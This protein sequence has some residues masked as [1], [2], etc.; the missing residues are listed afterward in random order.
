MSQTLNT[1]EALNLWHSVLVTT[2]RDDRP[3]LTMRQLALLL[4]VYTTH[5]PHTV[6]GLAE[7]L[8]I[9]KPAV[10]RALDRLCG[11]ELVRR[12]R[13]DADRRNVLIQRTV[14]GSVYLTELADL[15]AR[16]ATVAHEEARPAA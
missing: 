10:T 7:T 1:N 11:I 16:C 9:S 13:D 6:R 4:A 15:I 8:N 14:K 3:D 2:V 12:K 5:P